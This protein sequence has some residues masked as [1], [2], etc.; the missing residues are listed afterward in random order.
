M[1]ILDVPAGGMKAVW[2]T[3]ESSKH[4][5]LS[6]STPGSDKKCTVYLRFENC[7]FDDAPCPCMASHPQVYEYP[8]N[9][10]TS[11]NSHRRYKHS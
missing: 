9:R 11:N 2:R 4:S 6:T 5:E 1:G 10:E 8:R 3:Y 7:F